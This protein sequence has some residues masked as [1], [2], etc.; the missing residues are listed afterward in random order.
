[1]DQETKN[2]FAR[3]NRIMDKRFAKIDKKFE[4]LARMIKAGFDAAVTKEELKNVEKGIRADMVTKEEAKKFATKKDLKKMEKA[5]RADMA[6]KDDLADFK[7]DLVT[8]MAKEDNR[9][10]HLIGAS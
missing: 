4:D 10:R 6:T 1:M 7:G 3:T 9:I 5:I 8:I 2:E